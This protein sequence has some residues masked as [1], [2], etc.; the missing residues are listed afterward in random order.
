MKIKTLLIF[1]SIIIVLSIGVYGFFIEPQHLEVRHVYIQDAALAKVL[2]DKVV[3]HLS[4]LHIKS[5]GTMCHKCQ[6]SR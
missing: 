1:V 2:K 3:V 6:G 4:D 5:I